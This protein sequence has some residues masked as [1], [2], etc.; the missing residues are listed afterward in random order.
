MRAG[1]WKKFKQDKY[2]GKFKQKNIWP[3]LSSEMFIKTD[4]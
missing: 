2:W 3:I 1:K 4:S